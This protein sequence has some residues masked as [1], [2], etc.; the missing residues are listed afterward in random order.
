M[1]TVGSE[2][3]I[4]YGLGAIKGL[5]EGAVGNLILA[6]NKDGTLKTYLIFVIE[7]TLENE[8]VSKL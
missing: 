8:Y 7:Q 1:F 5:G 3:Q 2:G 4:I 6:R